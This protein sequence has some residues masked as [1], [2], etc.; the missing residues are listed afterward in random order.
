MLIRCGEP[1]GMSDRGTGSLPR[2]IESG[3]M[4]KQVVKSLLPTLIIGWRKDGAD[5]SQD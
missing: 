3:G 1:P 5:R 4:G 2:V